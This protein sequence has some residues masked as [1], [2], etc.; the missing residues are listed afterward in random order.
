MFT[1]KVSASHELEFDMNRVQE[2]SDQ[3][4]RSFGFKPVH[5]VTSEN[6]KHTP[7]SD[8]SSNTEPEQANE[9]HLPI[10]NLIQNQEDE[11]VQKQKT[12]DVTLPPVV[13]NAQYSN[14]LSDPDTPDEEDIE[15]AYTDL[16]LS[17]LPWPK[18]LQYMRE[19]E[20]Y[21]AKYF[22]LQNKR[23]LAKRLKEA[24]ATHKI[25]LSM[26]KTSKKK[27][28]LT[29]TG[30]G[31]STDDNTSEESELDVSDVEGEDIPDEQLVETC[32][33]C[34]EPKPKYDL[35]DV[36]DSA[37]K[38]RKIHILHC[39]ILHCRM[40]NYVVKNTKISAYL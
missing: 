26:N 22:S 17:N 2:N 10:V 11:C 15:Q 39:L 4:F 29:Q 16:S 35:L 36:K 1:G 19:S 24:K 7:Q 37:Q 27:P 9:L 30:T 18:I 8:S 20:S 28:E 5:R 33:F 25:G 3:L 23:T 6:P 34:G 13:Q 14:D 12:E 38:V 21:A 32:D 40:R 31:V